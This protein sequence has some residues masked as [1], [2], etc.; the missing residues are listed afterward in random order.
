MF[1]W[2]VFCFFFF[3]Q[4]SFSTPKL[5]LLFAEYKNQTPV[6]PDLPGIKMTYVRSTLAISRSI[7]VPAGISGLQ[8]EDGAYE[9]LRAPRRF[10]AL[11][12]PPWN[13]GGLGSKAGL[14]ALKQPGCQKSASSRCSE[15]AACS[16]G[17]PGSLVR[18]PRRGVPPALPKEPFPEPLSARFAPLEPMPDEQAITNE[19]PL[20]SPSLFSLSFLAWIPSPS[21]PSPR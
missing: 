1:C 5:Q 15:R 20:L 7:P 14:L 9:M 4:G 6:F 12:Q 13:G 16:E 18:A 3:F 10:V 8:D 19:C 11:E 21:S 17:A 2:V